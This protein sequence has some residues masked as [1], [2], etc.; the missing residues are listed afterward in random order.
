M[1]TAQKGFTLIEL[2]I[3][4]A[5][6]GI[7]AAVAIPAYTDYVKR[8]KVSEGLNLLAGMKV[9][10]L[11]YAAVNDNGD[12]PNHPPVIGA[13]TGGK[14]TTK[15]E[16]QETARRLSTEFTD[17]AITG[18]LVLVYNTTTKAWKCT[19]TNMEPRYLPSNCRQ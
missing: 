10:V 5:I 7:L 11:E 3:V 4:I 15:V 1:K 6:I 13:A 18:S 14:Y 8:A 19:H 9:P 12:W 17:S 16:I 2:M